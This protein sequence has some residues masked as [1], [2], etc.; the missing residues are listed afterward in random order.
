M[1]PIQ[2]QQTNLPS[3]KQLDTNQDGQIDTNDI[4]NSKYLQS[5]YFALNAD[6]TPIK[7]EEELRNA[8]YANDEECLNSNIENL[9]NTEN[10]K[11]EEL[12]SKGV[13]PTFGALERGN[14]PQTAI[15]TKNG[16][17][18]PVKELIKKVFDIKEKC[19]NIQDFRTAVQ[20][21]ISETF[22]LGEWKNWKGKPQYMTLNGK[23]FPLVEVRSSGGAYSVGFVVDG[24]R[25]SIVEERLSE[26]KVHINVS[27]YIETEKPLSK[28]EYDAQKQQYADELQKHCATYNK[29]GEFL[30]QN[31]EWGY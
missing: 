31:K 9:L 14:D 27:N 6:K 26:D 24:L 10:K 22:E 1:E 23:D 25:Y 2:S 13:K 29:N 15:R 5:L 20:E 7:T 16:E 18:M 8:M 12:K 3:F 28:E 21:Y 30:E 11:L 4:K 19:N 17:Q